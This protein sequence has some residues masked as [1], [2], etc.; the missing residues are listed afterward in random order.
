DEGWWAANAAHRVLFGTW[1]V[2]G[3]YTPVLLS[4]VFS[5]LI[6]LAY[7]AQG[8]SL[9]ATRLVPALAGVAWVGLLVWAFRDRLRPGADLLAGFF[10]ATSFVAISLS[11]MTLLDV[12]AAA[13]TV[14]AVGFYLRD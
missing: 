2:P 6:Y 12:P 13:L 14:A 10:A 8:V 4:P 1:I 7:L 9:A 3:D 11:R 5:F